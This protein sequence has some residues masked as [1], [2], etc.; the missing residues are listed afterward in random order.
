[1]A[2]AITGLGGTDPALVIVFATPRFD[3]PALLAG[4]R[5]V[6]GSALLIGSTGSGEIIAGR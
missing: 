3:L 5:S 2:E 1:M 6:T 4:V